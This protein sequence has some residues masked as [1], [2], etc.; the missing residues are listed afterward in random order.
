M[1]RALGMIALTGLAACA[2]APKPAAFGEGSTCGDTRVA[3]LVGQ[4]WRE[5]QRAKT[6]KASG[7]PSLRVI[8]PR[9]V[10]T[11]DFRPERLN[12]ETDANGRITR[13]KCG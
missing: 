13:I 12:I 9:T 6:L 1:K 4:V 3:K 7:A 5:S 10:V 11:M 2:P 8:A